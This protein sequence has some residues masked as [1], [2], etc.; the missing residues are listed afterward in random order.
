MFS[1]VGH[2]GLSTATGPTSWGA[3]RRGGGSGG[4]H[5]SGGGGGSG[6]SCG[7]GG[8]SGGARGRLRWSTWL[9]WRWRV[10][11]MAQAA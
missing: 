6:G 9:R 5:S 3:A 8:G 11:E 10:Q 2:N 7:S 4:A 1:L